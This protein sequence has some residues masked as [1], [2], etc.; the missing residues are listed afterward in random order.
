MKLI[1]FIEIRLL[2]MFFDYKGLNYYYR[3][4]FFNKEI[5]LNINRNKN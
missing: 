2:Y 3:F 5:N 4:F 1:L